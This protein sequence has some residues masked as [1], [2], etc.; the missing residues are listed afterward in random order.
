MLVGRLRECLLGGAKFITGMGPISKGELKTYVKGSSTAGSPA[1]RCTAVICLE[2]FRAR[3]RSSWALA[4]TKRTVAGA[5]GGQ[6][7]GLH[8]THFVPAGAAS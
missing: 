1:S 2:L 8:S 3:S 4:A 6:G 7:A 5:A